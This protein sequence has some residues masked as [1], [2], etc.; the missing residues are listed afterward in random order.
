MMIQFYMNEPPHSRDFRIPMQ[1]H[2]IND[3]LFSFINFTFISKPL[4]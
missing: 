3:E 2:I 1:Q 4:I